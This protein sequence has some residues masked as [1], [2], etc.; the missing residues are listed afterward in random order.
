M[1]H[2]VLLVATS[3]LLLIWSAA[4]WDLRKRRIPNSLVLA[5]AATG[6]LLQMV[7]AIPGGV[8]AAI[9]GLVVGLVILIPGYLMG[10]T[11]AGDVKLMAAI[12]AFIGPLGVFQAALFSILVGGVIGIGFAV[13][14]LILRQSVSP[15]PRYGLMLKTLA[16]TGK[17]LYIAPQEGEVMG[18]KFP[19]AVSIALGSSAWLIWQ[20]PL[21]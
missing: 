3:L 17:P 6:I 15:F 21:A 5:G 13:S 19:F 12:G 2:Q 7:L 20:W 9:T 18:R 8:M 11:G 16:V 10:F 14:A 1:V 4:V